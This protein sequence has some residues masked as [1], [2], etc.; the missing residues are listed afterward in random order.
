MLSQLHFTILAIFGANG[1]QY[2]RPLG[3]KEELVCDIQCWE[4]NDK[5]KQCVV[6]N[7]VR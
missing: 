2:A 1:A 4:K 6:E 3:I 7:L 5:M